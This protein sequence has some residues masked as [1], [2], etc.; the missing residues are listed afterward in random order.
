MLWEDGSCINKT[1]WKVASS[2]WSYTL[3]CA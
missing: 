3:G 2:S 1:W